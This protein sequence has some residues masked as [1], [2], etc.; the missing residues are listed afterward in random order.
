MNRKE[1]VVRFILDIK[2][3]CIIAVILVEHDLSVV[4]DIS[5][6]IFVLD[7]GGVIGSGNAQQVSSRS[8]H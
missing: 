6:Y 7:F 3:E 1:N 2:N 8:T 4:M 5:D